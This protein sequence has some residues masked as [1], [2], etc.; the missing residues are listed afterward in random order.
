MALNA[1]LM[2]L[3]ESF[4]DGTDIRV[5]RY[6]LLAYSEGEVRA[7]GPSVSSGLQIRKSVAGTTVRT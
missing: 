1:V 4:I 2:L 5:C 6:H 7:D 3:W